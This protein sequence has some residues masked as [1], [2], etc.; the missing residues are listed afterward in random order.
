MGSYTFEQQSQAPAGSTIRDFASGWLFNGTQTFTADIAVDP[1]N[2]LNG[3]VFT[4]EPYTAFGIGDIEYPISISL[5]ND[6]ADNSVT[7]SGRVS[8]W[9]TWMF[10]RDQ[11]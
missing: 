8:C 2:S 11:L 6:P 4:A 9:Y 7:L 5:A 1:N 3:R 10:N